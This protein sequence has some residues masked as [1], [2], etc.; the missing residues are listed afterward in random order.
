VASVVAEI[1]EA[2]RAAERLLDELPP[3]DPD[4]ETIALAVHELQGIYARLTAT[5]D[6]T[7]D[8]IVPSRER[9]EAARRLINET[10]ARLQ[11]RRVA[12]D[13]RGYGEAGG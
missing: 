5:S 8:V 12:A 2:W 10:E 6:G 9:L 1:L 11:G 3:L 7:H 13:D 4:H